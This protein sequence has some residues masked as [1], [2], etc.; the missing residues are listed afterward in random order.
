MPARVTVS[1]PTYDRTTWLERT[2]S[3]VVGQTFDDF[4][5]QVVDDGSPG[6]ETAGVVARFD[7]PRIEL[8]RGEE[9]LG[10]VGNF[11]RSLALART[12]YLLQLGD[13]DEIAPRLLEETVAV[14]DRDPRV[15]MVHTAFDLVGADGEL[16]AA[17]VDWTGGLPGDAVERGEEFVRESMAHGCRV[18]SS[19]A[20]FRVDA[21]PPGGFRQEDFPPFDFVFWLELASRWDVAFIRRALCR[22]RVHPRSHSSRVAELAGGGYLQTVSMSRAVHR[23]KREHLER[24]APPDR[25]RLART[26]DRA[27]RHDLLAQARAATLPERRFV[28]TVS[29]LAALVREEPSLLRDA[30]TW[31]L[32][33]GSVGGARAVAALRRVSGRAARSSARR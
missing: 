3:S 11:N 4:L 10:I 20:L 2:I 1:I 33:A 22:Y 14:L 8:V 15:G 17:G 29:A 6:E 27:L 7:D 21:A 25:N 24:H 16:F 12:E 26:A 19:T 9:N 32:L 13:D 18:C 30:A 23:V 5:L 31:S 28:A